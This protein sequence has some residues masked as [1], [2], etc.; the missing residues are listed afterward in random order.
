MQD[1]TET[2]EYKGEKHSK[3]RRHLES[4]FKKKLKL[5]VFQG[6]KGHT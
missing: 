3:Q 2:G 5:N 1:G 6:Q 4:K